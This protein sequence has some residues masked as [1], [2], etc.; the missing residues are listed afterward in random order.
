MWPLPERSIQT[1]FL[2]SL[3]WNRCLAGPPVGAANVLQ[4]RN[5]GIYQVPADLAGPGYH[6]N[7]SNLLVLESK[8]DIQK[9]GRAGLDDGDAWRWHL[10]RLW[11][12]RRSKKRTRRRHSDATPAVAARGGCDDA[13]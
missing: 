8:A 10:S 7:R 13:T 2:R 12:R 6:I 3:S 11:R 4:H 5:R 9:R 1:A